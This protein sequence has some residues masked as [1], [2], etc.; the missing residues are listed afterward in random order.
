MN[1]STATDI[2]RVPS[3]AAAPRP[4]LIAPSILA[5]D[6]GHMAQAAIQIELGGGDWVHCD[7]MD[8]H[9]VPNL[10]FGPDMIRALRKVTRLPLDVHLMIEHADRY[11][12][13]FIDAGADNVTVHVE[14]S[15]KHD[16][17]R[18]LALIKARGKRAGL[19]LNPATP[20][21]KLLPFLP[22][23]DQVLCMTVNPG[24]GGQSFMD[25]VLP[26]I[27][28]IRQAATALGRP[29]DIVVDG[30]INFETA[31]RCAAVGTNAFVAGN[32]LFRHKTLGLAEAIAEFRRRLSPPPTP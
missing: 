31:Q 8:G 25:E 16:V 24:F 12:E 2:N 11:L 9:F 10:T 32:F 14:D 28:Q 29:L 17:G 23:L 27:G 19:S 18:S 13:A 30:G 7:V 1:T 26:K 6:F 21:D 22:H 5:A 20:A 15:A 3:G 4:L